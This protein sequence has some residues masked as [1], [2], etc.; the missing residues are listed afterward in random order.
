M[1]R[2]YSITCRDVGIECEFAA[3]GATVEEVIEHC[4]S[5]GRSQHQMH[6]FGPDI[7]VKMRQSIRIIDEE[8]VE[9]NKS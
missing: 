9:P 7:F 1:A 6:S 4:A 2:L 3:R 5:H 8:S